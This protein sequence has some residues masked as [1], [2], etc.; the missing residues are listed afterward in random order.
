MRRDFHFSHDKLRAL[1]AQKGW[2]P[3]RFSELL[4]MLLPPDLA[5]SRQAV[6]A[7]LDGSKPGIDYL[8]YL[9]IALGVKNPIKELYDVKEAD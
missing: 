1:V 2:S 5:V 4:C 9:Q 3:S 7:W 8:P 6:Y